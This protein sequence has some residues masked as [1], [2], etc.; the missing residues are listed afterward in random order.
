LVSLLVVVSL[1]SLAEAVII[2]SLLKQETFA[3]PQGNIYCRLEVYRSGTKIWMMKI[4]PGGSL[5]ARLYGYPIEATTTTT[6]ATIQ[7]TSTVPITTTTVTSTTIT[8]TTLP[9]K[10]Y[11]IDCGSKPSLYFQEEP[12][13]NISRVD[14]TCRITNL[15][16]VSIKEVNV[17]ANYSG[18]IKTQ[19]F[20]GTYMTGFVNI[21]SCPNKADIVNLTVPGGPIGYAFETLQTKKSITLYNAWINYTN[22]YYEGNLTWDVEWV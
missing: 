17:C 4:N 13:G 21:P 6:A 15:G 10:E 8:T 12:I 9:Q 5:D 1:F 16:N 14:N 20:R 7:T 2:R 18:N 11:Q 19:L 22:A 3:C